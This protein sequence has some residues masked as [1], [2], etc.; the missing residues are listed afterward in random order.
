VTGPSSYRP[1]RWGR[2][3]DVAMNVMR[4]TRNIV[5]PEGEPVDLAQ[6]VQGAAYRCRLGLFRKTIVVWFPS[7]PEPSRLENARQAAGSWRVKVRV[8]PRGAPP[9]LIEG[10][11]T[12]GVREPR[13]PVSPSGPGQAEAQ[14]PTD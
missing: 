14:E 9:R 5:G 13:R 1:I 4:A 10:G 8:D 11:G 6:A 2:R 7:P 12:A 3:D